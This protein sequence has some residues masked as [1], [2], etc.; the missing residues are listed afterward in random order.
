MVC[1]HKFKNLLLL[2]NFFL[3]LTTTDDRCGAVVAPLCNEG[4]SR[5]SCS[6]GDRGFVKSKDFKFLYWH[7][8]HKTNSS[9][10]VEFVLYTTLQWPCS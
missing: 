5:V 2:A 8:V 7:D 1:D 3:E 10:S 4:E 6:V 9:K